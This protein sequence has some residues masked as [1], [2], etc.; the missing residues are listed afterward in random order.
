MRANVSVSVSVS[1][2]VSITNI[3][4]VSFMTLLHHDMKQK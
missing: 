4:S 3:A 1:A 2:I